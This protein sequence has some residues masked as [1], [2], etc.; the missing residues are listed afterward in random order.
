MMRRAVVVA[1]GL[2]V[3]VICRRRLHRLWIDAGGENFWTFR[4]PDVD[5]RP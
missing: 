3:L 5:P 4:D 2:A 1:V